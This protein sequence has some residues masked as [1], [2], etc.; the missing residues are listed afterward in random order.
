MEFVDSSGAAVTLVPGGLNRHTV[1]VSIQTEMLSDSEVAS[2]TAGATVPAAW[3][4]L[5]PGL[6]S[7]TQARQLV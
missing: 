1:D 2:A 5:S 4:D 3:E 7:P 6:L